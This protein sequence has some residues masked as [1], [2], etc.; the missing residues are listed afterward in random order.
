VH[1]KRTPGY[2]TPGRTGPNLC[3]YS[4]SR[5]SRL[6]IPWP[7]APMGQSLSLMCEVLLMHL[8]GEG[9]GD[10]EKVG[11]KEGLGGGVHARLSCWPQSFQ[12]ML[13]K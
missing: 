4:P 11:S 8:I 7:R 12:C 6:G 3:L 9:G 2:L 1:S 13:T 5:V 10:V